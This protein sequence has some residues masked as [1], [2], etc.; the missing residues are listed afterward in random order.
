[1]P[2]L[3]FKGKAFVHAHHLT[4][5]FR[6]LVPDKDKSCLPKGSCTPAFRPCPSS[7]KLNSSAAAGILASAM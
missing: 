2:S 1:M 3:D 7:P 6:E 5:P 4:V